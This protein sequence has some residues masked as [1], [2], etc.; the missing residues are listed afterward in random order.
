[1]QELED[2]S[3]KD[4]KTRN[5]DDGATAAVVSEGAELVDGVVIAKSSDWESD[6]MGFRLLKKTASDEVVPA[7]ESGNQ[8][9]EQTDSSTE[10]TPAAVSEDAADSSDTTDSAE[11]TAEE[12]EN[13]SVENLA[14][15]NGETT[16]AAE[17]DSTVATTEKSYFTSADGLLKINTDGHVGYYLFKIPCFG[18]TCRLCCSCGGACGYS[19]GMSFCVQPGEIRR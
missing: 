10:E 8:T 2:P 3:V 1:M 7:T 14:L 16:E 12:T 13:A 5:T 9:E 18:K 11:T 19:F 17:S 15:D 6:S 4:T